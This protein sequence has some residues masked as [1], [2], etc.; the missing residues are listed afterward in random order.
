MPNLKKKKLLQIVETLQNANERLKQ[1]RTANPDGLISALAQCQDLAIQIGTDIDERE[2]GLGKEIVHTLE[3]YCEVLYQLTQSF[4]DKVRYKKGTEEV[5]KL[6]KKAEMQ[7]KE[8]LPDDKKEIVFFPY[9]ASMWDSLESVYLKAKE[10]PNCDAYC[11]PIPYYD[12]NPDGNLGQMH[13]EGGEYP[14]NIEI[15]NWQTYNFE[16]RQPD[17]IYIHNPY[18]EWNRVTSVHPRFYSANLKKYTEKLV[19]I[20]YFVLGEIDPDNQNAVERMK[21]FC[22]APGTI[23]ADTVILQSENMRQIYIN[24]YLK[25]AKAN[26]LTGDHIDRKKLEEKFL[27]LG[28]PKFDKVK[29][30]KREDLEVPDEWLKIIEKSD[31]SWKKIIFYN[32]G[33]SALLRNDEQMLEKIKWA[34][35]VFKEHKDEVAL[36]WRPHPLYRTTLESMRPQLLLDYNEIVRQYQEEGWG[37]YDDS[38]E[39]D[40]AVVLCDAYYGDWSSVVQLCQEAGKLILIQNVEVMD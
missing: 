22:F 2:D 20:P 27:G 7:I 40:R 5:R 12:R 37:I 15:T 34:L 28:S 13:Y 17:V 31:R 26:N 39:L 24:E 30:T 23:Y 9:K 29:N 8:I 3:A 6:L 19:Y 25:E 33:I 14:S 1:Q 10:D 11:V 32:T 35:G 38:T 36:L 16:E 4:T 18:D 21:H